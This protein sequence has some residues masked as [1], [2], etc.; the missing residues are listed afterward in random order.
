[1]DADFWNFKLTFL[2]V[3]HVFNLCSS[4]QYGRL[5]FWV[6]FDFINHFFGIID[7]GNTDFCSGVAISYCWYWRTFRK[8]LGSHSFYVVWVYKSPFRKVS[9]HWLIFCFFMC[10]EVRG[11]SEWD[12]NTLLDWGL[13]YLLSF[14]YSAQ[15]LI[16]YQSIFRE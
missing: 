3:D 14:F 4:T 5:G 13:N 1:M 9:Q 7:Q 10:R 11:V 12:Y 2:R 15:S 8:Q 6:R 16:L